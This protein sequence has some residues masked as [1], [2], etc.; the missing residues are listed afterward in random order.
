MKFDVNMKNAILNSNDVCIM[1]HI[2][3]DGDGLGSSFALGM[4]L[5]NQ[6]KNVT[7]A[8]EEEIP[9]TY[10][11]LP[12]ND[13]VMFYDKIVQRFDTIIVVDT[14][15]EERIGKRSAL[16]KQT[17]NTINIDHHITNTQFASFNHVDS[18]A[19]AVGEI[20]YFLL[21]DL[22]FDINKDIA[23]NIYVSIITD[24][25]SFNHCNTTATCH[26]VVADLF[27]FG[28]D[29]SG[30]SRMIN[31]NISREN[32]MLTAEAIK[33]VEMHFG[34]KLATTFITKEMINRVGATENDYE[35]IIDL[36][37]RL[38]NTEVVALLRESDNGSVR[39]NLRSKKYVNVAKIAETFTGGGHERAAGCTI[40]GE[41]GSVK[42]MLVKEIGKGFSE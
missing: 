17:D 6:G 29:V 7:I 39:V 37:R 9:P 33:T 3:L 28:L 16:L 26:R 19:S 5:K 20:I 2:S 32:L 13:M 38:K 40:T 15:D 11:F 14:G 42:Q 27:E 22:N 24:T 31:D 21:K 25:G 10:T 34:G 30:I 1:S 23:T 12:G 18:K 8:V 41:I 4:A 36:I 35:G